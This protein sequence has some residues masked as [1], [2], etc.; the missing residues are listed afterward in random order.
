MR[1]GRRKGGE[2]R[3]KGKKREGGRGK[4][5]EGKEQGGETE[6][7]KEEWKVRRGRGRRS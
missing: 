7:N 2:V 4:G 5:E 6:R 3:G 1:K